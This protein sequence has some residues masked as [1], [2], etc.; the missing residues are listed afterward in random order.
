MVQ[1][2]GRMAKG[3]VR[4]AGSEEEIDDAAWAC[5]RIALELRTS[6]GVDLALLPDGRLHVMAGTHH[7][8]MEDPEQIAGVILRFFSNDNAG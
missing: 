3:S 1:S 5:E 4:Q 7:L 6:R 8:H 2:T